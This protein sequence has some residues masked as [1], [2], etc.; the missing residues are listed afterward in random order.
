MSTTTAPQWPK[1]AGGGVNT[2]YILTI[3]DSYV[4]HGTTDEGGSVVFTEY[5]D[6]EICLERLLRQEGLGGDRIALLHGGMS[7]EER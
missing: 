6:V 4:L 3:N 7:A 5:R 1:P 2:A